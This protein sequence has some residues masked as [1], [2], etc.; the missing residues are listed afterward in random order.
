MVT[1]FRIVDSELFWNYSSYRRPYFESSVVLEKFI[2]RILIC[3]IFILSSEKSHASGYVHDVHQF[4][5]L[6]CY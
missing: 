4:A 2:G 1:I 5:L 3:D 6:T